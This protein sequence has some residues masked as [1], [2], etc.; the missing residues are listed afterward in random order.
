MLKPL[1]LLPLVMLLPLAC[2][3]GGVV[4]VPLLGVGIA[5]AACVFAFALLAFIVRLTAALAFGIGGLVAGVLGFVLIVICACVALALLGAVAH[6]LVP[7][8]VIFGVVW[9]IRLTSRP[10]PRAIG[11]V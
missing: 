10:A 3:I 9:L 6:L 4:I 8:L 1:L 7:L 5:L 2:V 11:H